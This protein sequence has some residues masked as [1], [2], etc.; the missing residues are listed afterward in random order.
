[1]LYE[2]TAA[3][4]SRLTT[5]HIQA[6]SDNVQIRLGREPVVL[7]EPLDTLILQVVA[8]RRRDLAILTMLA[9]LGL[10]GAEVAAL[11]LA[12]VDWRGGEVAIRGKGGRIERLPLPVVIF[13]FQDRH[14]VDLGG[15][16]EDGA[17]DVTAVA[18]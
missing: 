7:P 10:R 16:V 9:R 15:H 1:M 6:S 2:Q 14:V 11:E 3:T 4:V 18:A 12:D 5:G 8:A 17:V 13:S